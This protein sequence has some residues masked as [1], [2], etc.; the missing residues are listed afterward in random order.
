CLRHAHHEGSVSDGGH[1]LDAHRREGP[2]NFTSSAST[3]GMRRG[4]ALS[5]RQETRHS[6]RRLL[7]DLEER[8]GDN[9][10]GFA[11]HRVTYETRHL[12]LHETC[13]RER[14]RR[15]LRSPEYGSSPNLSAGDARATPRRA[16]PLWRHDGTPEN[17][18]GAGSLSPRF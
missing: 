11:V 4:G 12:Q 1:C 15:A 9:Y 7:S 18:R 6:F 8:E 3:S 17:T 16:A 10:G 2:S 5:P 13:Q 14:A